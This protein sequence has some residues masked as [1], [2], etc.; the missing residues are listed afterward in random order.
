MQTSYALR[1]SAVRV[2]YD[3]FFRAG[4]RCSVGAFENAFEFVVAQGSDDKFEVRDV[5]ALI[6]LKFKIEYDKCNA[7][8]LY[9]I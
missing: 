6:S 1:R 3:T 8:A 9:P 5:S 2:S 7:V 4:L